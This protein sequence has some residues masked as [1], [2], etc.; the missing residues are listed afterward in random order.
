[1]ALSLKI[2]PYDPETDIVEIEG[3]RYS[4]AL[5]RDGGFSGMAGAYFRIN[6]RLEHPAGGV[7][8]SVTTWRPEPGRCCFV[9]VHPTAEMVRAGLDAQRAVHREAFDRLLPGVSHGQIA[10]ECWKA[11]IEAAPEPQP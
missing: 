5:F 10:A 9:P 8:I 1:M 7:D 3:V 4:G 2:E 11:M 6:E